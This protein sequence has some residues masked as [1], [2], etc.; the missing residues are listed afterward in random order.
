[1]ATGYAPASAAPRDAR[2]VGGPTA[3][4]L[5]AADR[6]DSAGVSRGRRGPQAVPNSL[7]SPPK[8]CM[9]AQRHARRGCARRQRPTRAPSLVA[10]SAIGAGSTVSSS[11][12]DIATGRPKVRP[13]ASLGRPKAPSSTMPHG[14]LAEKIA[15]VMM[16]VHM[17]REVLGSTC[18]VLLMSWHNAPKIGTRGATTR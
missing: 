18:C 14:V 13:A 16:H 5:N 4:T 7:L 3:L 10:R 17:Q 6:A 12:V 2:G 8:S 1:M 15:G 11:M 9:S